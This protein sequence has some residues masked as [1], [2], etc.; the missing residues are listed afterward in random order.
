MVFCK[1]R[2]HNTDGR[3]YSTVAAKTAYPHPI[4]NRLIAPKKA[5]AI[6]PVKYFMGVIVF[7]K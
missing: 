5:S 3:K 4:F 6:L 1:E 2:N 7:P